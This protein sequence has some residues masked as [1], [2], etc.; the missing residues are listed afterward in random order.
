MVV[1]DGGRNDLEPWLPCLLAQTPKLGYRLVH[2]RAKRL[3]R[4]DNAAAK[5]RV[6]FAESPDLVGIDQAL[7][8]I[9]TIHIAQLSRA[10]HFRPQAL[11]I[12]RLDR[13]KNRET[14][15]DLA[16]HQPAVCTAGCGAKV[17]D[18]GGGEAPLYLLPA[19]GGVVVCFIDQYQVE[20]IL[21]KIVQPTVLVAGDLLN[22]GNRE[23]GVPDVVKVHAT[24]RDDRGLRKFLIP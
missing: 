18:T 14:V 15:D 4:H 13:S 5:L 19:F 1:I 9:S 23:V 6:A 7:L 20:E 8:P 22:I 16:F 17:Y 10:Q 21:F 2:D 12:A 11:H 24:A 3:V